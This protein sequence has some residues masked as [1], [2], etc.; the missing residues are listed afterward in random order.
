MICGER[1]GRKWPATNDE[2]KHEELTQG[3]QRAQRSLK[4][5]ASKVRN[6]TESTDRT[7]RRDFPLFSALFSLYLVLKT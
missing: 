5:K 4:K 7:Q 3:S 6:E 2:R 1:W